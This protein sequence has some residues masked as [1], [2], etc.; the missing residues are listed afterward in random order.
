MA[1]LKEIKTHSCN[2]A[3]KLFP[4]MLWY[5][6][7]DILCLIKRLQCPDHLHVHSYIAFVSS[8]TRFGSPLT[9]TAIYTT[10][11]GHQWLDTFTSTEVSNYGISSHPSTLT[12]LSI[13]LITRS[14]ALCGAHSSLTSILITHVP[15]FVCVSDVS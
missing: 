5:E 15:F 9:Q 11:Q 8:I 3:C 14:Y 13:Q 12:S 10:T 4:I 7:Q 6:I 2:S 1:A